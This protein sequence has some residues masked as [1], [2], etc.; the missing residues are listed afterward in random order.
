M[1]DSEYHDA[2]E[3]KCPGDY[4]TGDALF[5]QASSKGEWLDEY[6][7]IPNPEEFMGRINFEEYRL[8][9]AKDNP[10]MEYGEVVARTRMTDYAR[11]VFGKM[12]RELSSIVSEKKIK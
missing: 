3:V 1:D 8:F 7:R 2:Y 12:L 6:A 10:V 9:G 5:Y 4:V 11:Y